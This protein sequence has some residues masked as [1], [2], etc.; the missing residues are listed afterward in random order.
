MKKYNFGI[1]KTCRTDVYHE[2]AASM[3]LTQTQ[4][5]FQYFQI[6]FLK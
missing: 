1:K 3:F 2:L 4:T 6:E 5:Q